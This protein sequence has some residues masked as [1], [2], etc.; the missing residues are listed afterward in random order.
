MDSKTS[1]GSVNSQSLSRGTK[2]LVL[3]LLVAALYILTGKLGFLVSMPPG[4]VT[5]VWPPSGIA[6]AAILRW[7]YSVW[8]GVWLG[9]FLVNLWFFAQLSPF[10]PSGIITSCSI[11]FGST[12]QALVGTFLIRRLIGSHNPFEQAQNVFRFAIIEAGSCFMGATIGVMSLCLGS[13]VPWANASN[14]WWTWWLGDLVGIIVVASPLLIWS[15]PSRVKRIKPRVRYLV[16]IITLF[17][18]LCL[19]MHVVFGQPNTTR[20]I[21][22]PLIYTIF[23]LVAWAAFRLGPVGVTMVTL[24]ISGVA[25]WGTVNGRGPFVGMTLNESLW[26]LQAFVGIVTITGLVLSASLTERKRAEED[27]QQARDVLERRVQERTAEFN[28]TNQTL[29][30]Q[31]ENV[32][33]LNAIAM[34]READLLNVKREVDAL[35]R[36]LGRETKYRGS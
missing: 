35:L 5:T 15:K 27:L 4:N 22:H 9:S 7:G 13:F 29:K 17:T 1:N 25:I 36:E 14:T 20:F 11:A 19:E 26:M 21:Q 18:L 34:E 31:L 3:S 28:A 23:P 16:E 8:P 24:T 10:S 12:L 6:L 2:R 33:W 30:T 32:A